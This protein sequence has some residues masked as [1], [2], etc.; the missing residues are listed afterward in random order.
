VLESEIKASGSEKPNILWFEIKVHH[1]ELQ[2]LILIMKW[3]R[4]VLRHIN[5]CITWVRGLCILC[6]RNIKR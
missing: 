4:R 2:Q 1:W 3:P 5:Q 6:V